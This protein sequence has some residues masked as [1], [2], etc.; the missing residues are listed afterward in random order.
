MLSRRI[1]LFLIP[2]SLIVILVV[3]FKP[4]ADTVDPSE[5]G[6]KPR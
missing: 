5:T 3:G 4:F 2:L 1:F 6:I